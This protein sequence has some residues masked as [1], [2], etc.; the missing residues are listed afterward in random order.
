MNKNEIM[1][2]RVSSDL[3][4]AYEKKNAVD[5]SNLVRTEKESR[6][7]FNWLNSMLVIVSV[8][9]FL[10]YVGFLIL[11]TR[12][13]LENMHSIV[14]WTTFMLIAWWIVSGSV[15]ILLMRKYQKIREYTQYHLD[16]FKKF[17]DL[18]RSYELD[19]SFLTR[20]LAEENVRD[21]IKQ[22]VVGEMFLM[23]LKNMGVTTFDFEI[24]DQ[25]RSARD[26]MNLATGRA[27]EIGLSFDR[28]ELFQSVRAQVDAAAEAATAKQ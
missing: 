16:Q 15:C 20:E 5:L 24:Q 1:L 7:K 6:K 13:A 27:L 17:V 19:G 25:V 28:R 21:L 9:S 3:I 10:V 12:Y 2:S 26:Q 23:Q 22:I 8:S 11:I 4:A 14:G 18:F